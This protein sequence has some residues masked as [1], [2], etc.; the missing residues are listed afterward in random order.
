MAMY[1]FQ[2]VN[3]NFRLLKK[4]KINALIVGRLLKTW[5]LKYFTTFIIGVVG[6]KPLMS[7]ES[8]KTR[9]SGSTNR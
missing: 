4:T 5:R 1:L 2:T 6:R 3:S 8:S 9:Q 7:S